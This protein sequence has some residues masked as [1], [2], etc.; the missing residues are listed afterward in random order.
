MRLRM[1]QQQ[2]K[3]LVETG[4]YRPVPELVAQAMLAR[5]GVR[6]LLTNGAV[7]STDR[8]HAASTGGRQAA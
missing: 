7:G 4:N 3:N 6:A 8:I 1:E 2:L 5:R